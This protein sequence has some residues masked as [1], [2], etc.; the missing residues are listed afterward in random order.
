[1]L[2]RSLAAAAALVG[3]MSGCACPRLS[4][5]RSEP[6]NDKVWLV[7]NGFHTSIAVRAADAPAPAQALDGRA[8]FFII[9]WGGRDIYM[10]RDVR[11]WQWFTSVALPTP[12]ALHVIPVRSSLV[13]E[14]PHSEII[15]FD[16]TGQGMAKLRRRLDSAFARMPNGEPLVCGP[17]K[18][19]ASRFMGGTETYFL[20]K[21]CTQWA[22]AS[23]RSAGVPVSVF[24]ALMADQLIGRSRE[25]GRTLATYRKPA[26]PL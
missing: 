7:S 24:G 9:G 15:E 26:D 4:V 21:N 5:E 16:V 14:C 1:M 17:G 22:A 25:H 6:R 10:L 2:F 23:L 11:P 3:F 18:I 12:S 8:K 13:A 20:P 19:P